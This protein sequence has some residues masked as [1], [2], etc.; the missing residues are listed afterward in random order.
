[1][2]ITDIWKTFFFVCRKSLSR[3]TNRIDW[4]VHVTVF[5]FVCFRIFF[6]CL[7]W[8]GDQLI[9]NFKRQ[10][11]FDVGG[12]W[13]RDSSEEIFPNR[14]LFIQIIYIYTW[15]NS[16]QI[17]EIIIFRVRD[18]ARHFRFSLGG[19]IAPLPNRFC[20][21]KKNLRKKKC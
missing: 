9:Y 8:P 14:I 19:A 11:G 4:A 12:P 10:L 5:E 13:Y 3:L 1:M 17:Y 7:G 16:M 18:Q 21:T 6:Y 2:A 15:T 20:C